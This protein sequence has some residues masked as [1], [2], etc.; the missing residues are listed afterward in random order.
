MEYRDNEISDK[1]KDSAN[2]E[3]VEYS[4]EIE[5][6]LENLNKNDDLLNEAKKA[7]SKI[8]EE[9]KNTH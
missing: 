2:L 1:E 5:E 4:N 7:L 9:F 6:I 3:D 8:K